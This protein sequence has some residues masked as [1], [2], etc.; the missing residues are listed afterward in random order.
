MSFPRYPKY[1]DSGVEWLGDVPEH[2]QIVPLKRVAT[3]RY[4]IGEPPNYHDEGTPLIRATNVHGGNLFTDGL[5]FVDPSEIP[6]NELS[7]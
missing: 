6:N 5:V 4:G 3:I 7:G 2:W 1:K